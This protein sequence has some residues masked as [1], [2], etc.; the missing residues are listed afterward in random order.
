MGRGKALSEYQKGQIDALQREG[1]TLRDIGEAVNKSKT[2]VGNYLNLG[3]NYGKKKT[4]GRPHSIDRRSQRQL[5]RSL[6][7]NGMSL[8]QAGSDL[9]LDVSKTSIWRSV[10][11]AF[12][13]EYGKA[14]K[15]PVLSKR[16]RETRLAFA[17]SHVNFGDKWYEVV[18]TDEK[19]L[20][21]DGPDGM[22]AKWMLK[23]EE[24]PL[25]RHRQSNGGGVM[26]WA[27]IAG[28]GTTDICLSKGSVN[29]EA[30][31]DILE[32]YLLDFAD[33][34]AGD[35]WILL[36]DGATSHTS[37]STRA[38]LADRNVEFLPWPAPSPDLN[39]I[40]NIW[41]WLTQ[42][43]YSGNRSYHSLKE[44]ESAIYRAWIDLDQ[45]LIQRLIDSMTSRLIE[46]VEKKVGPTH[47]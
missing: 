16:H 28:N 38:W 40:E 10:N 19:R 31:Q 20:C 18:F 26:V 4:T 15:K 32:R 22:H 47:Y 46:V 23:G 8:S 2:V 34:I 41:A 7:S 44:L 45:T 14:T 39:V 27:G 1:K 17:K 42:R 3:E 35:N 29:S 43:I 5:R 37:R 9:N 21:L 25:A 12:D 13:I 30:Y 36:Q 24:K 33:N 11:R 6:I